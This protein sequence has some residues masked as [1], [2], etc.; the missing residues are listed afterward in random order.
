[1][2]ELKSI[3]DRA[4]KEN[5]HS[6][7][8]ILKQKKDSSSHKPRKYKLISLLNFM[9]EEVAKLTS[10]ACQQH[11]MEIMSNQKKSV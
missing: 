10:Q 9:E 4:N 2:K 11:L 7:K 6:Q 5:P 3:L 8:C 1:M